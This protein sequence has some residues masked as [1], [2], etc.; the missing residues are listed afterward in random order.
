M[1]QT[2]EDDIQDC[3]RTEHPLFTHDLVSIEDVDEAE[4]AFVM[5]TEDQDERECWVFV[6]DGERIATTLVTSGYYGDGRVCVEL[7]GAWAA[8]L[9]DS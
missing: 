8:V 3:D 7:A 6:Q 4:T 9:R 1:I 2:I 5:T